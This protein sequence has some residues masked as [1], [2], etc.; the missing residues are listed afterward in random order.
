MW[1][2][3]PRNLGD[4]SANPFDMGG[5]MSVRGT[6]GGDDEGEVMVEGG[7]G[8]VVASCSVGIEASP[9]ATSPNALARSELVSKG[10]RGDGPRYA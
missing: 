2:C 7:N 5:G 10:R 1:G 4:S 8:D 3:N 6:T 9:K